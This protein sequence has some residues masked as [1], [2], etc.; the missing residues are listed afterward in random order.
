[1]GHRLLGVRALEEEPVPGALEVL[2]VQAELAV[3]PAGGNGHQFD[4]LLGRQ[5]GG[6]HD[7][8]GSPVVADQVGAVGSQCADEFNRVAGHQCGVVT[9][10]RRGFG[11]CV[12]AHERG[13]GAEA[14]GR[15]V[16][17]QV[18]EGPGVVGEPVEAD[19]Q[20]GRRPSRGNGS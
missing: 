3:Y 7:G 1:M 8:A 17:Q 15:Q 12:A 18:A 5:G 10:V 16:W 4:D 6:S 2:E 13:D 11:R 9:P 19:G 14:G 20:A